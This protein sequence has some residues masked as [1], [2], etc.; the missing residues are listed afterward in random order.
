[1]QI[2]EFKASLVYRGTLKKVRVTQ[3]NPASKRK[4]KK[5]KRRIRWKGKERKRKE[6]KKRREKKGKITGIDWV[7]IS[8]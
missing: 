8:N 1:M 3:R 2:S 4:K 7:T 5:K 6:K